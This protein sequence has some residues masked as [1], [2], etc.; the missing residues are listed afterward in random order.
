M[1]KS[2]LVGLVFIVAFGAI[3]NNAFARERRRHLEV[4]PVELHVR[5]DWVR[6]SS[7]PG[8]PNSCS[9]IVTQAAV[10]IER[11]FDPET[12]DA[13]SPNWPF[14]CNQ[15]EVHRTFHLEKNRF[16]LGEPILV[17]Y[18]VTVDGSG[19]FG[20][21][22]GGNYRHR[23][24][25][26]NFW[27]LMRR[28]DGSWVAD[29]QPFWEF[30]GGGMVVAAGVSANKPLSTWCAVQRWC[31][32]EEPGRY[33]LFCLYNPESPCIFGET[34]AFSALL[35]EELRE[36]YTVK[37]RDRIV[38]KQTGE[39]SDAYEFSCREV[40]DMV[41][42]SPTPLLEEMPTAVTA[43]LENF[44]MPTPDSAPE[45]MRDY[46]KKEVQA[47]IQHAEVFAHFSIEIVPGSDSEQRVMV[48]DYMQRLSALPWNQLFASTD[49]G[50][51]IVEAMCFARQ[52]C[53]LGDLPV[54]IK[55]N[56]NFWEY[57]KLS[58]G[59]ASNPAPEAGALL[60]K[61]GKG[62]LDPN[63]NP[64]MIENLNILLD[65]ED[66]EVQKRARKKLREI[67]R[68]QNS[69]SARHTKRLKRL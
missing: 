41:P 57:N 26:D 62:E 4:L 66:A 52:P 35:P 25:S 22:Y 11:A 6:L 50:D 64:K 36:E 42:E 30:G 54:L 2:W 55:E 1:F 7:P 44:D 48:E 16:L 69:K 20:E 43:L 49:E 63:L 67:S 18:C 47:L 68:S 28:E 15:A 9:P 46:L 45:Y 40:L 3:Q 34:K 65:H 59:L 21:G 61:A 53:F 13:Y 58:V 60:L 8:G 17:E 51:A 33:D 14:S 5:Q 12:G 29:A 19:T 31:A 38:E 10:S 27:F 39:R 24:R 32:I 23:G 37:G 56:P